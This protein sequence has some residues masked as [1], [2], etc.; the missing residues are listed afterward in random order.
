MQFFRKF[1]QNMVTQSRGIETTAFSEHDQENLE[2]RQAWLVKDI[3]SRI[4][5]G[6]SKV[7]SCD[8]GWLELV[9]NCHSELSAIDP[10]YTI[11][12]IKEKFGTLRYYFSTTT[13]HQKE[14]SEI[15]SKY[16]KLSAITC[17]KTGT[18]GVLMKRNG[19]YKTL[20]PKLAENGF[21]V[22]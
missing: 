8:D 5:R 14:M 3:V 4:D 2:Q 10:N 7:I 15:V 1:I 21:K 6:Y 11:Y 12:Q 20:N 22:I 13:A 9:F 17:E 16:E 18:N 19:F